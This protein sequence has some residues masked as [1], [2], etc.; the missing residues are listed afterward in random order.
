MGAAMTDRLYEGVERCNQ[1][2]FEGAQESLEHCY[3]AAPAAD[4][5]FVRAL[6]MMACG[7]HLHFR[8][9]GGRGA[10]NLFRQSLLALDDFRPRHLGVEVDELY[11]ALDAYVAD[12]QGRRKPGAG[13][14]DR[15]LAPRIAYRRPDAE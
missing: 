2:D 7:L 4:Q 3:A 9:G 1:G 14:F 5:P 13:F 15:W 11:E 12:L 6:L 8:R 10:L